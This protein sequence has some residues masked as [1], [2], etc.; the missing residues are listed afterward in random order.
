[1][2]LNSRRRRISTIGLLGLALAV[3]LA[4]TIFFAQRAFQQGPRL[5]RASDEAIRPWMSV[6]YI[7]HAFHVPP[8][9][10][11][12]ALGL[13]PGPPPDRRPI[14]RIARAQGRSVSEITA[15]LIEAINRARPPGPPP[16]P[17]PP[18]ETGSAP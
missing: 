14:E 1:M 16:P 15:V 2:R 18:T 5:R 6:P 17:A 11:F 13:P 7:A 8:Q 3:A 9:V 4:S 12:E 10:L